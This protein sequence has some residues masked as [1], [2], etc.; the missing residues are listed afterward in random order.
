MVSIR[1]PLGRYRIHAANDSRFK[2]RHLEDLHR[3]LS[4]VYFVPETICRI[5]ASKG[6]ELDPRV[7]GSTSREVKLRMASIRLD[8]KTHPIAG[9]TRLGLLV[10]GIRAS[11]REPDMSLK[12]RANADRVVRPDGRRADGDRLAVDRA[13]A[14]A[15]ES[16]ALP[17]RTVGRGLRSTRLYQVGDSIVEL[18]KPWDRIRRRDSREKFIDRA[19][20]SVPVVIVIDNDNSA[21]R[22]MRIEILQADAGGFVP[23]AIESQHCD[24]AWRS[25]ARQGFIEPSLDE[26]K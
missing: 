5:A 15:A 10:K 18:A 13:R 22:D 1:A 19:R 6:I 25:K 8:P 2:G 16:S 7:L 21:R 17:G 24:F 23:V 4:A 12:V 9:D 20:A 11:L 3:R 26:R 14:I